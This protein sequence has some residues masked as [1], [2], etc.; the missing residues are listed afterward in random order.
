MSLNAGLREKKR[1]GSRSGFLWNAWGGVGQVPLERLALG[2]SREGEK[3]RKKNA[4]AVSRARVR[5]RS[6]APSRVI[7][8]CRRCARRKKKKRKGD[9]R[10]SPASLASYRAMRSAAGSQRWCCHGGRKKKK[11]RKRRGTRPT[12]PG[13]GSH[14]LF[15]PCSMPHLR[16]VPKSSA[17]V[18]LNRANLSDPAGQQKKKKKKRRRRPAGGSPRPASLLSPRCLVTASMLRRPATARGRRRKE[19]YE[20]PLREF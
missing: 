9:A 14:H 12:P 20:K 7:T 19:G 2:P 10:H 3:K 16:C 18:R 15:S 5:H 4:F 13:H 11:K 1:G 6:N 8:R 17:V